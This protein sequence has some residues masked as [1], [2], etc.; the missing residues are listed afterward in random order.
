[1]N[2]NPQKYVSAYITEEKVN[3]I[4]KAFDLFDRDGGGTI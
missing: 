2:F 4:K 1:M 3:N